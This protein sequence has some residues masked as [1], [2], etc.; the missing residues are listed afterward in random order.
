MH[1]GNATLS[2]VAWIVVASLMNAWLSVARDADLA[3]VVAHFCSERSSRHVPLAASGVEEQPY[4]DGSVEL[5]TASSP[6]S[7]TW[8]VVSGRGS[9]RARFV[10]A[11][12]APSAS[13]E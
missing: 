10:S 8:P 1:V 4:R 13:K 6:P 9:L 3:E 11:D 5:T 12:A 2:N 7:P